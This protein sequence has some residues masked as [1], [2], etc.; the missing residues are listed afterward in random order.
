MQKQMR[1]NTRQAIIQDAAW[2]QDS[3]RQ[4]SWSRPEGYFADCCRQQEKGQLVLL[5]AER[6]GVYLGHVKVVWQSGYAYFRENGVPH[7]QDLVVL[8]R[9]RRKGVATRLLDMAEDIIR[10]GPKIA[11]ISFGL[12]SDYG[13][14]QRP[15]VLR[16]YVPDGQGVT[17]KH[18][19]VQPGHQVVVDDDLILHLAKEL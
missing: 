3:V 7:I 17:Y 19:Y 18:Q 8:P 4:T 10:Q 16:G 1:F 2:M 13:A 6:D 5:V 15:Y 11:G 12:Y 14:A 9:H